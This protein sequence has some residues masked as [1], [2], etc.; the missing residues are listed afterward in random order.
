MSELCVKIP[1]LVREHGLLS[2]DNRL[3][4]YKQKQVY[5]G[6]PSVSCGRSTLSTKPHEE[7]YSMKRYFHLQRL[8]LLLVLSFGLS[9]AAFGQELTG[10]LTGTVKDANGDGV[11]GASVTITDTAKKLVVRTLTTD[12]EGS[13]TATELHVGLYDVTVE[14]PN[15]KKHLENNVKVDV[16]QR[17]SL[18]VT[19]EVGNVEEVVTVEA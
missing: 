8:V 3:S 12:D 6:S 15:F 17:R 2:N 13:F 14:A 18:L 5:C 19:L 9:V 7:D 16:G 11:K 4:A 10:V 1:G